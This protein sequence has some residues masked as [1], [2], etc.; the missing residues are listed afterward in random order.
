MGATDPAASRDL[1][2]HGEYEA[3][4]SDEDTNIVGF[5]RRNNDDEAIVVVPRF[6]AAMM[7]GTPGQALGTERWGTTSIQLP[8]RLAKARLTNVITG[9]SIEPLVHRG[10]P[11]LL[12][13][14][15]FQ[16]WPVAL[17]FHGKAR[18]A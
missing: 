12:M 17:L 14:S 7:R 3:L 1:F 11:R 5:S 9:E 15:A 2:I 8:R 13:A 4:T 6:L 10:T 18:E 16:S